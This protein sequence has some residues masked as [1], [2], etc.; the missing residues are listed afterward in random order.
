MCFS[1]VDPNFALL[2]ARREEQ[3]VAENL[4]HAARER[5]RRLERE[6]VPGTIVFTDSASLDPVFALYP[7]LRVL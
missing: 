3:R 5:E 2:Y 7:N 4:L 6:T 1:W